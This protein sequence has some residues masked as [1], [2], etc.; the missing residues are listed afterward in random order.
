MDE[1]KLRSEVRAFLADQQVQARCDSWMRGFD[2]VFSRALGERGW[3]GINVPPQYGGAGGTHLK[4]FIVT[5][6]LL[7]AGAPVA[8]HWVADR[9]IA[10]MLVKNGTEFLRNELLPGICRGEVYFCI[11]ISEPD[12]G[13]DMAS[14]SMRAEREERDRWVLNGR[15][16]WTTGAHVAHYIFVIARSS[17]DADR[18]S[19][20]TQFVVPVD[21]PGLSIRPIED[22]SGEAHFNEL[23]FDNAIVEGSAVVGDVGNGW[24]QILEQLDYERTGPERVLTTYPLFEELSRWAARS[25]E[26]SAVRSIGTLAAWF[27][28]LRSLSRAAAVAIDEGRFSAPTAAMVKD[29]GT[30]LEQAVGA[31]A[32]SLTRSE[33]DPSE[34]DGRLM[35]FIA[36]A[37]L[38]S[39]TFTLR[40]GTT[41]VLRT[42][43]ARRLLSLPS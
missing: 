7:R 1:L 30:H 24:V 42:I 9:Q 15:K 39:P 13:S 21:T 4:R 41:E 28:S 10:P 8:A 12:A 37:Q 20:L 2:P 43:I 5:E 38:Y 3:L 36:Q 14:I 33:V 26:L 23:H 16:I 25:G 6:E 34:A 11:A 27:A 40:G 18:H 32:V 35:E 31:A 17:R 22:M 29:L 19:G